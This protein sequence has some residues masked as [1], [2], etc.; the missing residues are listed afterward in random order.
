M[1][2]RQGKYYIRAVYS[3]EDV[4]TGIVNAKGTFEYKNQAQPEKITNITAMNA[5]RCV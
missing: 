4:T 2:K 3:K 1:Y 5:G